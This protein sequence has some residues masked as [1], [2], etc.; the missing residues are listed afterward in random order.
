MADA[1][2]YILNHKELAT[3][4]VKHVG[5]HEGYWQLSVA[6]N[7]GAG[8]M[9]ASPEELNPMAFV[10]V[11][12]VGVRR[13]DQANPLTVNAAEVNPLSSSIDERGAGVGAPS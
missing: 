9:G 3:L 13:V 8:N 7:L 12:G 4:L 10:A 5:V 11:N 1:T 6:F 2:Q